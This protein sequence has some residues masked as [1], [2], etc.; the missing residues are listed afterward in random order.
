MSIIP[1]PTKSWTAIALHATV[2][3]LWQLHSCKNNLGNF[4]GALPAKVGEVCREHWAFLWPGT[5][6]WTIDRKA[7]LRRRVGE[8]LATQRENHTTDVRKRAWR[9]VLGWRGDTIQTTI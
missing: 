3:V 6:G 4:R 1:V 7:L 9:V 2:S 5:R 8:A